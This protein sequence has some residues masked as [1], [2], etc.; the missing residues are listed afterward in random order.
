M[1]EQIQNGSGPTEVMTMAAAINSAFHLGMEADD[2]VVTLGEDLADPIGGVFKTSKGL[3]T[4]FGS[5]RVWSTPIA[6]GA[7]AGAAVGL[8]LGGY[9]PVAEVM[10]FDFITHMMDQVL[11]HAAKFRYMTGGATPTP[12]TVTTVI[13]SSHYGAQHSQSLEAWFM[14][15]PGINVVMPSTPADAKGLLMTCMKSPDPCLFIQHSGLLYTQKAE[16]PT[17]PYEIPFGVADVI[18][19][20]RDVTLV[21]YGAQRLVVLEVAERLAAQGIDAEVIDLRTLV[22]LDLDTIL[23]SVERTRRAVIVHEATEFAG[24][25]AEISSRIHEQLFNELLSPVLR[26]GSSFTPVPFSKSVSGYPTV[27]KVLARVLQLF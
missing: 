19:P 22:P 4:K 27:E 3:S 8:S 21:T 14:H 18:R 15:T 10:F 13:G 5:Q 7:I 24:P 12:M 6:E 2:K 26:V 11:N 9:R 1:T 20:G 16:V 17:G 25:G 23:T